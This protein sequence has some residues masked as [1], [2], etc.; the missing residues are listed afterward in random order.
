MMR[1]KIIIIIHKIHFIFKPNKK[2]EVIKKKKHLKN[3][4]Y[5]FSLK[6]LFRSFKSQIVIK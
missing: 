5:L 1:L 3:L 4:S 2:F 6:I